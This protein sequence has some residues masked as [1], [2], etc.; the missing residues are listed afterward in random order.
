MNREDI[1][2][3]LLD[4]ILQSDWHWLKYHF[5][6][7]AKG[8]EH[9]L[10]AAIVDSCHE[11]E[12]QIPGFSEDF[13]KRLG[14][15]SG[16]EKYLPHYEQIIQLLSEMYVIRQL[17]SAFGGEADIEHE[18]TAKGSKKNPEIGIRMADRSV[19]FE[20][21]CREFIKHHNLRGGAEIEL[22]SRM[23]GVLEQASRLSVDPQKIVLP[24]DNVVKDFL[25]SANQKFLGFK[26]QEPDSLCILVVV[27]DDYIYEPISSL[28]NPSS[29][30]LTNASFYREDGDVVSFGNIDAILVVR[31]S[32]HIVAA[33]KDRPPA[34]CLADALD[35]GR[36]G[37]VLPKALIPVDELAQEDSDFLCDRLEAERIED[38][39]DV[40]DYRPQQFV[41]RI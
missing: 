36:R 33:T 40:A 20:V 19:Y 21:K 29:G 11:I 2:Q 34:D 22:P 15:L 27:W 10:C 41:L 13:S 4:R 6:H 24:R 38:L 9:F 8:V 37:K 32:H 25:I 31:H 35:W 18:P 30:L 17:I 14:A 26:V 1:I 5:S 3:A 7:Y 12:S 28:A 23:E 16:R 39:Q